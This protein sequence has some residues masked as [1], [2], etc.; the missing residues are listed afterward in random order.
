VSG[1]ESVDVQPLLA[2]LLGVRTKTVD[3]DPQRFN[4]ALTQ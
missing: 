1:V 4:A 2:R 3:G